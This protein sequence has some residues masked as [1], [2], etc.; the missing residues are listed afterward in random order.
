[1]SQR[2][3]G[4]AAMG[5]ALVAGAAVG[6]IAERRTVGRMPYRAGPEWAELRASVRGRVHDVVSGDGTALHVEV[7]GPDD[8]PSVILVHGYALSQHLWHYQRRDLPPDA[9]VVAYDQRGHAESRPAADGDYSLEALAGDLR[10]VLEATVPAGRRAVV[11]GHSMGGMAVMALAEHHPDVVAERLAGAALVA[12]AASE[13]IRSAAFNSFVN[14]LGLVE[15]APRLVRSPR[16]AARRMTDLSFLGTK[17]ISLNPHASPAHVAFVEQLFVDCPNPVKGALAQTLASIDLDDALA[18]LKV[19]TLV[20]VGEEDR[21]TPMRHA[22]RMLELLPDGRLVVLPG[23]GHH[24]MLEAHEAF[25]AHLRAFVAE[26][27]G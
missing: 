20:V 25:T 6:W 22:R 10:A 7:L 1:V 14:T 4:L 18:M 9:R 19:P 15:Q 11:V 24:P 17:L 3:R 16:W 12:T 13:L 2:T 27:A 5:A 23:V 8:A 21:L 26:V